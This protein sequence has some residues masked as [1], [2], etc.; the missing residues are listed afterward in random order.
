M[1]SNSLIRRPALGVLTLLA[2]LAGTAAAQSPSAARAPEKSK[3][4]FMI[5]TPGTP[6]SP[7]ASPIP[8]A[9]PPSRQPAQD[10]DAHWGVLISKALDQATD[11]NIKDKP[12]GDAFDILSDQTGITID[13]EPGTF[14]LLPNESQTRVNAT[15]KGKPLRDSLTALLRPIG[16]KFEVENRVVMIRPIPP[17]RRIAGRSTWKDLDLLNRLS[18]TPWDDD[19]VKSLN[20]R[21]LSMPGVPDIS[22]DMLLD[23]AAKIGKGAASSVLEEATNR[24][25]LTWYPSDD[26]IV[27]LPK[28]RQ[29]QRQLERPISVDYTKTTLQDALAD[30]AERAG[31]HLRCDPGALASLS[32][33]VAERFNVKAENRPIREVLEW[34]A[35]QTGLSYYIDAEGLRIAA[36]PLGP[37][38]PPPDAR[39]VRSSVFCTVKFPAAKDQPE[40]TVFLRDEDLTEE[41]KATLKAMGREA[42]AKQVS[43][44][45]TDAQ[46]TTQP[47]D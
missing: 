32:P 9:R 36:N 10:E 39:P 21:F 13:V 46:V 31:V 8:A 28:A 41:Q 2:M 47:H 33:F 34:I 30:L 24:L 16:L 22:R 26:V 3:P 35:G 29:F 18:T 5:P 11:L 44:G 14:D 37:T 19:Y 4:H 40:I 15:I 42:V 6:G 1:P 23:L 45:P 7:H 25:G 27:V 20:F 17:L 12:I 38:T 43:G